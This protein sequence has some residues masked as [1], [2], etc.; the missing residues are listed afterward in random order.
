MGDLDNDGRVEFWLL[1]LG[2]GVIKRLSQLIQECD[3]GT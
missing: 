3:A 1:A 2:I